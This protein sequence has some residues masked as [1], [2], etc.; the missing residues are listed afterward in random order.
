[1]WLVQ[2]VGGH[3]SSMGIVG[4]EGVQLNSRWEVHSGR[5]CAAGGSYEQCKCVETR[6]D[7]GA[8]GAVT[9]AIPSFC[10]A[11]VGL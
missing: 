10:S 9:T 6:A 1:M 7:E 11:I 5:G 8:M 3:V 2:G 4:T